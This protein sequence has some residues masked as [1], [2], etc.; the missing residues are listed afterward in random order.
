MTARLQIMKIALV[1]ISL[2]LKGDI[3]V[4]IT[5]HR[6]PHQPLDEIGEIEEHIQHLTLLSSVDAFM[7]HHFVTQVHAMMHKQDP[8]QIDSRESLK[9]QY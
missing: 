5:A 6:Q 8:Q 3:A 1:G 9:R 2:P 7:V 4:S